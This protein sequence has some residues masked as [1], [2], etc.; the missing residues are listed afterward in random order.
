MLATVEVVVR[1]ESA[2]L[3]PVLSSWI[4]LLKCHA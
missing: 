3:D 4:T 2:K 1:L